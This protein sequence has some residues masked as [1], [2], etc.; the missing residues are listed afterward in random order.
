MAFERGSRFHSINDQKAIELFPLTIIV[1]Q[2]Q[3][4]VDG[5]PMCLKQTLNQLVEEL[6]IA[7]GS[8]SLS[9]TSAC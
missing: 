2:Y 1:E 6:P 7:F 3:L 4:M 9:K 8:V 5:P